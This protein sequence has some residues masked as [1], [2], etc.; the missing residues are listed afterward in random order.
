MFLY[1]FSREPHVTFDGMKGISRPLRCELAKY[2]P[3]REGSDTSFFLSMERLSRRLFNQ[4]QFLYKDAEVALFSP[5]VIFPVMAAGRNNLLPWL[6]RGSLKAQ[7]FCLISTIYLLIKRKGRAFLL[8]KQDIP[9]FIAC[10]IN[11]GCRT[12][13]FNKQKRQAF[14]FNKPIPETF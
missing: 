6:C 5:N 14:L 9:C 11:K 4:I 3:K 8:I 10:L 2:V 7:L 13:W 12:N 1:S